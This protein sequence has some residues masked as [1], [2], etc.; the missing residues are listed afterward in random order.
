MG[1]N[2]WKRS[3][4]DRGGNFWSSSRN[5]YGLLRLSAPE[6]VSTFAHHGNC[7]L[8]PANCRFDCIL[9]ELSTRIVSSAFEDSPET[10]ESMEEIQQSDEWLYLEGFSFEQ[11]LLVDL[12]SELDG[13]HR[14]VSAV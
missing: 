9:L 12:K 1:K 14:V 2:E 5:D 8:A 10:T 4:R 6:I 13:A 11:K 7:F 3:P